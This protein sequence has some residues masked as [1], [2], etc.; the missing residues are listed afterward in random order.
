MDRERGRDVQVKRFV[1]S[2]RPDDPIDSL[3]D[4]GN[5]LVAIVS[6][7]QQFAIRQRLQAESSARQRDPFLMAQQRVGL[8]RKGI[9]A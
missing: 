6:R 1:R 7:E 8:E 3:R 2:K 5:P 4:K 9:V